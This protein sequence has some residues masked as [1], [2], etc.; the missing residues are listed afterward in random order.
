MKN[1]W[2]TLVLSFPFLSGA[3][4]LLPLDA[5]GAAEKEIRFGMIGL[6]TSHALG[7]TRLLNDP[8]Q[9]DHVAGGRVVAAFKEGSPDLE[10]ST[11]RID[12]YATELATKYGVKLCATVEAMISEV[13]VVLV[14]SVDGRKHLAQAKAAIAAGKPVFVDK[15]LAG[16]LRAGIELL[17]AA[18]AAQVPVYSSSALRQA[19]EITGLTAE[20]RKDLRTAIAWGPAEIEPHHPD[21]FWYGVHGVEML[22]AMLGD[23]CQTVARIYTPEGDIVTGVWPGGR[24]GVLSALRNGS[25]VF[26]YRAILGKSSLGGDIKTSYVPLVKSIVEFARTK[27]SPVSARELLEVLAFMEAADE[28]KRQGG[29]PVSV[30]EVIK[31]NGG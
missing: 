9:P 14:E 17:A 12:G 23:G 25:Y 11:K 30:A 13:D 22:Y 5:S 19:P 18:Q 2:F 10:S 28:S 4:A 7:F 20:Q 3:V 6:D 27:K 15:P 8:S 16:S 24:T 31:A 29:K 26:G 1:R 21:L